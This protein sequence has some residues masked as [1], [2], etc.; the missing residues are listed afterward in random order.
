M[1]F[2]DTWNMPFRLDIPPDAGNDMIMPGEQAR[3][4]KEAYCVA[5]KYNQ[6]KLFLESF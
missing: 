4:L 3:Y 6:L 2:I 5:C 1:I